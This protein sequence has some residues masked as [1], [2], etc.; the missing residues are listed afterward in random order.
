MKT[1]CNIYPDARIM[2]KLIEGSPCRRAH[3]SVNDPRCGTPD[4]WGSQWEEK[5]PCRYCIHK[6]ENRMHPQED[7]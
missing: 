7:K 4:F 3:Y 6:K 1:K 5:F 2:K